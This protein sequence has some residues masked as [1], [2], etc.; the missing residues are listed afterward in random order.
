MTIGPGKGGVS[1]S[2]GAGYQTL[3]NNGLICYQDNGITKIILVM[4][5]NFPVL[6]AILVTCGKVIG[7]QI[8]PAL[9]MDKLMQKII[10]SRSSL[11]QF[12]DDGC[13]L[14]GPEGLVV[15]R[16]GSSASSNASALQVG[17][18]RPSVSNYT[19]LFKP[20]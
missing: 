10:T 19:R 2:S 1:A 8:K 12:K 17:V 4:P 5:P 16:I 6:D 7:I 14:L 11:K 18:T 13:D 3:A 15:Y 9:G 20:R